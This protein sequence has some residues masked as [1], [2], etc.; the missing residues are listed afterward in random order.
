[1]AVAI[2]TGGS[3]GMGAAIVERF[4][5][6]GLDVANWD[7][8]VPR[9]SATPQTDTAAG[10]KQCDIHVDV[11]DEVSVDT[12]LR[13]TT[14]ALGAPAVL[15]NC[16]GI[17][18]VIPFLD[19]TLQDWHRVLDVD[20]TGP[21]LCMRAAARSM[22]DTGGGSIVNIA[23]VCSLVS[24][25][26]R[27]PYV[28]AKSGLLGLTRSA[29]QDLAP[30]GIRV[31]AVAPGIIHTPMSATSGYDDSSDISPLGRRGR[32]DE[33]ADVVAFLAGSKSSYIN[34]E[35]ITVDGGR[36]VVG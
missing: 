20:L 28:A 22:K 21:F 27:A 4:L 6:D 34:G 32:P 17:R 3:S 25:P 10:H 11:A 5:A 12:A 14:E 9:D 26:D 2:V 23:S 13:T 1:M 7:I 36:M 31:N 16:A 19:L 18:D 29:A 8:T 15:V 24:F 33:V 35:M 30:M